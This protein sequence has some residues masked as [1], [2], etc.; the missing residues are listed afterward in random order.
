MLVQNVV[1]RRMRGRNRH[2]YAFDL[3]AIGMHAFEMTLEL[4]EKRTQLRVRIVKDGF[5]TSFP[6]RESNAFGIIC[7]CRR[8]FPKFQ[9]WM[10]LCEI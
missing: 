10:N 4:L 9:Q 7:C 2:V 5:F 1:Q 3:Q 6:W 8:I